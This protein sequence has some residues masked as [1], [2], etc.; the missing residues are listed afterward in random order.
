MKAI[1]P[2]IFRFKARAINSQTKL[3]SEIKK[4]SASLRVSSHNILPESKVF[5]KFVTKYKSQRCTT[6]LSLYD[7]TPDD[8][9][10]CFQIFVIPRR[11]NCTRT[12]SMKFNCAIFG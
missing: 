2:Q 8:L 6:Y 4:R 1:V 12:A 11:W 3:A 9:H 10:R 7:L 5:E